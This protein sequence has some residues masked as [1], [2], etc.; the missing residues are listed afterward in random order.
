MQL[1]LA[2][3]NRRRV[4]VCGLAFIWLLACG[5]SF[6]QGNVDTIERFKTL[7]GNLRDYKE[8]HLLT[9]NGHK[10][11]LAFWYEDNSPLQLSVQVFKY[12]DDKLEE[13]VLKIYE[14]SGRRGDQDCH[15]GL[16]GQRA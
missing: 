9:L 2:V 1:L 4:I 10:C 3:S 6:P 15:R 12:T 8:F 14:G 7:Y 13:P 16:T 5:F 11:I